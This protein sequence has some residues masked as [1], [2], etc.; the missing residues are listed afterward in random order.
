MCV[1]DEK[2]GQKIMNNP[3]WK[4]IE[5]KL[6]DGRRAESIRFTGAGGHG[7]I[8][9]SVLLAQAG[10]YDGM[11][12]LQS[13]VYGA[14]ARGG[15]T[16]GETVV[17]K[18][19]IHYPKLVIPDILISL[20]GEGLSKYKSDIIDTGLIIYD[21]SLILDEEPS[22]KGPFSF[23]VPMWTELI[24]EL[25]KGVAINIIALGILVGLTD[26]VSKKSL[27]SAVVEAFRQDFK[28]GNL[29]ALELAYELAEEIKSE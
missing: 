28:E 2:G 1:A 19:K 12:V 4:E 11:N 25:G 16:K 15:A 6:F 18:G 5:S 23:G 9:A 26:I 14:E 17:R 24:K 20:T 7:M 8:R 13:Q 27:E 22:D 10:V 3:S 29:K 21:S